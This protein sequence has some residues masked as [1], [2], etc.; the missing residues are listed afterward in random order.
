MKRHRK[1][2]SSSFEMKRI[3]E[4]DSTSFRTV[5]DKTGIVIRSKDPVLAKVM[6]ERKKRFA[7]LRQQTFNFLE[8][9]ASHARIIVIE[10]ISGSGKDT[11]QAYLKTRLQA[12]EIYDFSEGELLHSWKHMPIEGIAPLRFEF[13]QLFVS[14]LKSVTTRNENAVFLLNRFHLS[15]YVSTII[16]Q[17]EL[18]KEYNQT[19]N[20]LRR[21]P[22]HVFILQ[23]DEAEIERRSFHSERSS[24]WQKYQEG[25]V[26]QDGFED[27]LKR[28]IWQQKVII[29]TAKRQRI[30][31]SIIK[32]PVAFEITDEAAH[33]V[34]GRSDARQHKRS[35]PTARVAQKKLSKTLYEIKN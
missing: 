20:V 26:T 2:T 22:I 21:L 28:F 27:R 10:G 9:I 17:P 33:A 7:P 15:T 12:R 32:F 19:I 16:K 31:Y 23:L 25:R 3:P 13:I 35:Y 4:K 14:Y 8:T 6:E 34:E 29:E 18:E 30:P 24:V 5:D 11:F 1:A